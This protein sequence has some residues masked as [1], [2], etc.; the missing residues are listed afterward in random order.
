MRKI[1]ALIQARTDSSRLPGKVLKQILK[2]PMIIHQLQRTSKSKYIQKL[3][4]ITSYEKSDDELESVVVKYGFNVYRG[5]KNNVLKRFVDSLKSFDLEDNDIVVRLTGDCPLHEADII[6][7]SIEAFLKNKCDYL[8]NCI[9]PVYP[10][11]F[12]VEVFKYKCLKMAYKN[13]SLESDLEHVTPYIRESKEFATYN[14]KRKSIHSDWRLTVDEEVDFKVVE[15][16]YKHF[17][18]TFFSLYD[19]ISYIEE[20]INLLDLN[21]YIKRNEGY[22]KSV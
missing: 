6:D 3:L 20:N 4:L 7:E 8:T 10:D 1:I 14:L 17:N 22:I 21:R 11:G 5:N 9:Q 12:D 2:K 16:I 18:K 15:A 19:I 13:A